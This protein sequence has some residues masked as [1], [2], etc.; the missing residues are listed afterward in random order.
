[1]SGEVL[2]YGCDGLV[3]ESRRADVVLVVTVDVGGVP[4]DFDVVIEPDQQDVF[5]RAWAE[6]RAG[7]AGADEPG[8]V[9]HS[10]TEFA[11]CYGSD[12]PNDANRLVYED[13][14]EAFEMACWLDG[15][16]VAKR[17]VMCAPWERVEESPL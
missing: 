12:D 16:Y 9:P 7:T 11:A 8:Y 13:E 17:T 2:A 3:V 14:A 5:E 1:M 15:G 6:A 10:R 4:R